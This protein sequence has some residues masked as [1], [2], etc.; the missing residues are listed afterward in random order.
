MHDQDS[1]VSFSF[2]ND[3]PLCDLCDFHSDPLP[4][5]FTVRMSHFFR[6]EQPWTCPICGTTLQWALK[7][8]PGAVYPEYPFTPEVTREFLTV[9]EMLARGIIR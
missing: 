3:W 8:R 6:L 4:Q 7:G 9:I 5:D 1:T 2:P